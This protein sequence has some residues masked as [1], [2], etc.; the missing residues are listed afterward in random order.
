MVKDHHK[1]LHEFRIE[2]A[3]RTDP[4]LHDEVVKAS[5]EEISSGKSVAA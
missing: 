4:T 2:A 1:D 5:R 3:S